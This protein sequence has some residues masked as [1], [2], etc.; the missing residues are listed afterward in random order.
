MNTEIWI[1]ISS[2]LLL[3]IG[4]YLWQR[5][6][7]VISSGRHAEAVVVRNNFNASDDLYTPVVRFETDKKELV[8][9]ELSFSVKPKMKEGQKIKVI[10]DPDNP[11]DI[12]INSTFLLEI[13]PRLLVAIGLF[14]L[15]FITL[16]LLAV[17]SL[18]QGEF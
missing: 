18:L 11:S 8:E 1:I 4:V 3:S 10:Y 16:E 5:A 9:R 17:T 13:L 14:G 12:S 6:T 2:A 15:I 7:N